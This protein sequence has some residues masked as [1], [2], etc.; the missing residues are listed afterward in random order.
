MGRELVERGLASHTCPECKKRIHEPYEIPWHPSDPQGRMSY[1]VIDFMESKLPEWWEKYLYQ[2]A[3]VRR[4]ND[5]VEL[6]CKIILN[7]QLSII[8]LASFIVQNYL[9]MFYR[10]CPACIGRG[11]I[12]FGNVYDGTADRD[13]CMECNGTGKIPIPEYSEAIKVIEEM[14]GE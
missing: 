3:N 2:E 14:E 10:E 6:S 11:F 7:K 5:Y 1:E 12:Q 13:L 9:E 8:H 4:T